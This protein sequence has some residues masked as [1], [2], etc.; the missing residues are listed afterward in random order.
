MPEDLQVLWEGVDGSIWDLLNPLSPVRAMSLEGLGLPSFTNSW[1]KSPAR[2][3]QRYESTVW[4]LN[5]VTVTV[6]VGDAYIP[7]GYTRRRRGEDWRQ[8]DRSFRASLSPELEGRLVVISGVGRRELAVRLVA[9]VSPPSKIDPAVLGYATYQLQ[10]TAGDEPWW[11]GNEVA[12]VFPWSDTSQPF[13]GG[14]SG[15]TLLY[16]SVA[17]VFSSA[18]IPNPGDRPAYARWWARGPFG[19][20][21]VGVGEEVVVLPLNLGADQAV[22]VDSLAQTIVDGQGGNLWPLMGYVNPTWAPIPAGESVPL[23]IEMDGAAA[24]AVVGVSLRP[25]YN[26]P[27]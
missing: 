10:L 9:P 21:R 7:D 22:Y 26:A 16:I 1:S 15:S 2:D 19:S 13:F 18:V 12:A 25:R 24:G 14:N 6:E 11:V 23:H 8:L 4:D 17:S 5:T 27:W 3:G 20:L